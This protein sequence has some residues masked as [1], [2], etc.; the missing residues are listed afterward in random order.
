MGF[1]RFIPLGQ[2]LNNRRYLGPVSHKPPD[3]LILWLLIK[4]TVV[5]RNH[6][7]P[8]VTVDI[9]EGNRDRRLTDGFF[10][11]AVNKSSIHAYRLP[12]LP[13]TTACCQKADYHEDWDGE[14]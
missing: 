10:G 4:T 11:S 6:L 2:N 13:N 14:S 8:M 5:G 9:V 7:K 12:V 1:E 3:R